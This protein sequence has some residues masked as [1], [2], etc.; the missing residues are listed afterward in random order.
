[1]SDWKRSAGVEA[2]L[3]TAGRDWRAVLVRTPLGWALDLAI[4]ALGLYLF[5]NHTGHILSAL[6]YLLLMACPLM[7]L[8]MHRG[9]G[10]G[11]GD[12]PDHDRPKTASRSRSEMYIDA[13]QSHRAGLA[14]RE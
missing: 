3:K 4:A 13:C 14:R 9:H 5:V 12:H 11:H 10:H 8:F 6:P 1:M 2:G 7:H